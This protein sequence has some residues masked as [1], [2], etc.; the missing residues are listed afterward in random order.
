MQGYR[1]LVVWQKSYALALA[2]YRATIRFP[3]SE[4]VGMTSQLRRASLS[5]PC[6]IAEGHCRQSR[7]DHARFVA[8]AQG[9]AAEVDTLLCLAR[10][11]LYLEEEP[12]QKLVEGLT[13][14]AKMLRGLTKSLR[15]SGPNT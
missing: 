15:A 5:I 13:E 3:R 7:A 11:L 12:A 2:V 10:D 8:I 6:N 1:D 4:V 14:V 9:S